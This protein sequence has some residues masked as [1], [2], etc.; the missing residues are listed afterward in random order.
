MADFT[1]DGLWNRGLAGAK[2]HFSAKLERYRRWFGEYLASLG[3]ALGL[4][5]GRAL[6]LS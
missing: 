6:E 5:L 4:D 1:A 2:R 3:S